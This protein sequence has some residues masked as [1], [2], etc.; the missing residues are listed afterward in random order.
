MH[1]K[2]Y[3]IRVP[4]GKKKREERENIFEEIIVDN[5]HKREGNR[6]PEPRSTE[7]PK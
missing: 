1:T 5:F 2:V 7:S 4:E 3:I 6:Y